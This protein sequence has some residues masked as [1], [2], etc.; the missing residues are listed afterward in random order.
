MR[1]LLVLSICMSGVSLRAEDRLTL[2]DFLKR[3][4]AQNLDL[5]IQEQKSKSAEAKSGGLGIPAPMV[6]FMQ[7][8]EQGGDSANGF[9]VQQ[10]IPF[11]TKI[12]SS[13]SARNSEARAEAEMLAGQKSETLAYAKFLYVSLWSATERVSL[14]REKKKVVEEHIKL[15]RAGARS[16]SFLR[17]HT[18][19]AESDLDFLEN[20]IL[21]AE[22]MLREKQAQIAEFLNVDPKGFRPTLTEPSLSTLPKA[23][24]IESSPQLESARLTLESLK[25]KESEARSTWFPDLYLRYKELGETR[26]NPK[27]S[28]LMVGVSLPFVFFWDAHSTSSQ[29]AS[30]RSQGEYE[31]EKQKRKIETEKT[32]LLG[33][34]ES[35]RKQ[36]E[37]IN[38]KLLPRAERRMK[39]AHN[40]APRDMETLQDHRETMEAF[41][42]LKL[43]SLELRMQYEETAAQLRKYLREPYE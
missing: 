29:A 26:M 9:E 36:L 14:F 41:P 13:K 33:R 40:V 16:D 30:E 24:K 25:S 28:E 18:L 37:N 4:Q 32:V 10:M 38:Q 43:K 22:Q 3:V 19:R 8:K 2:E 21:S 34:A 7:M 1:I 42:D 11:P 20:E 31:F 5:K 23:E 27:T 17:I 35:L 12:T 15:S 6:G 39:L